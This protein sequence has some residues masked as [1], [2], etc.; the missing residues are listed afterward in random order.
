MEC[1][2]LY[3]PAG[4][5]E[6]T[7]FRYRARGV[8]LPD[9]RDGHG[10]DLSILQRGYAGLI[11]QVVTHEVIWLLDHLSDGDIRDSII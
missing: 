9:R 8:G 10:R 1:T 5:R 2:L 7:A 11:G 4:S 6:C 3:D